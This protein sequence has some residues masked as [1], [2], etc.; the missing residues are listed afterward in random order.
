MPTIVDK[1][2]VAFFKAVDDFGSDPYAQRLHVPEVERWARYLLK[3]HSEADEQVVLLG[4]WLHDIGHYPP[5][6]DIDHA[7][8]SEE[9]ARAFL[10][11]EK[12]TNGTME[13][14]L[15]CVRAH[16][17]KDV[18]PA[19]IEAKIVACADSASHMTQQMYFAISIHDKEAKRPFRAYETMDRDYRDLAAFPELQK[20]LKPL[21]DAWKALI[22][23][24]EKIEVE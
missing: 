10:T 15:H 11:K 20:E 14:V 22:K 24:Y 16:R 6:K 3:Q 5:S 7:V 2:Q 21:Y 1:A 4:V 13:K 23:A 12:C 9:R 17:C 18:M 8:V 19:T